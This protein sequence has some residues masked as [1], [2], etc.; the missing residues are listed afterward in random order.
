MTV[1]LKAFVTFKAFGKL[2]GINYYETYMSKDE[3]NGTLSDMLRV[4]N[5]QSSK[6]LNLYKMC[7]HF[8]EVSTVPSCLFRSNI[9][10][11]VV[12][13]DSIKGTTL[14]K[15]NRSELIGDCQRV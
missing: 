15:Q 1:P 14:I 2:S 11:Y 9:Q 13:R 12:M 8:V 5:V 4:V 10:K 3:K 6:Q 7:R